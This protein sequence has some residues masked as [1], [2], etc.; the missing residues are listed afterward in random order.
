MATGSDQRIDRNGAGGFDDGQLDGKLVCWFTGSMKT[1]FDLPDGLVQQIKI[2]AVQERKPLKR[3]VADLLVKGLESPQNPGA[4]GTDTLPLGL[5]IN[6]HGFP[7]IRCGS[8]A[9]AAEMTATE[10][11]ALEQQTLAHEDLQRAR[12]AR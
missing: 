5:E 2:R 6:E 9:P 1:T 12:I 3:F 10:L 4:A 7:V 11:I 8:H